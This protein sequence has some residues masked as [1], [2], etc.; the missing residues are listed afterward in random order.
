MAGISCLFDRHRHRLQLQRKLS[1]QQQIDAAN[2]FVIRTWDPRELFVRL[3]RRT[4]ERDLDGERRQLSEKVC[5]PLGDE[6]AIREERDQKT[7]AL[8]VGIDV[9]KIAP[10]ENLAAAEQQPEASLLFQLIEHAFVL[11]ERELAHAR[12]DVVHRQVVVAVRAR[13]RATGS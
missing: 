5:D 10:R 9:Q 3:A 11:I 12:R 13:Q 7:F 1:L 4:V 6:R 2:A 8:R